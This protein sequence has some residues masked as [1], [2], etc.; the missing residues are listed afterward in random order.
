MKHNAPSQIRILLYW[1]MLHIARLA[2]TS[3]A[4]ADAC[5]CV[6]VYVYRIAMIQ[7]ILGCGAFMCVYSYMI[8]S[9]ADGL[10]SYESTATLL[11]NF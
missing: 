11:P 4:T 10:R 6:C 8:N 7:H 2:I 9:G 5:W 1:E 3:L